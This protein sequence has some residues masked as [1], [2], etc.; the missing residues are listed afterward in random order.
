[1]G[2][3]GRDAEL[4]V[5]A[6][7]LDDVR[8]GRGRA[9]VVVGEPGIGKTAL[10]AAIAGLAAE[11]QLLVLS[12]SGADHP[13]H[14]PFG[15]LEALDARI[16]TLDPRAVAALGPA[17]ADA[18]PAAA[19]LAGEAPVPGG[20]PAARDRRCP[21]RAIRGLLE[22]LGRERPP[23]LLLDDVQDADDASLELVRHL[24]RRPLAGPH[25]LVVAM[26]PAGGAAARLLHAA[27]GAP[28]FAELAL[29]PLGPEASL[30]LLAGVRDPAARRRVARE[31]AGN[32]LFLR[33][34]ASAA[35]RPAPALPATLLAAVGVETARLPLHE[36]RLL[37]GAAAAGDPFDL[38]L[39]AAAAAVPAG[40]EALDR[41]VAAGV[42]RATGEGREFA[43]RHPL[44]RRAVYEAA[45][46]A[47]RLEAH[48]RAAAVLERRGASVVAR[49]PHL[50]RCARPGDAA[51]VA[52]LARAAAAVARS[53]PDTAAGWYA[54]ALRLMPH[55]ARERRAELTAPMGL[56]LAAAGRL[57]AGR[58]AL[59]EALALAEPGPERLVLVRACAEIEAQLGG[60]A[61]ARG[62]LR[63]ALG[64]APGAGQAR[65]AFELAADAMTHGRFADLGELAARTAG[66]AGEDRLLGAGADALRALA[67][68]MTAG[69]DTAAA[70]AVLDGAVARL[71]EL[72]DAALAAHLGVL[73]QIGRVQLRLHRFADASAT[74]AR[75]LAVARHAN[76]RHLTVHLHA[77]RALALC[78]LLDL[79]G[80]LAEVEAAEEAARPHGGPHQELFVLC[81][82]AMAHHHRGEAPEAERAVDAFAALAP[83]RARSALMRAAGANMAAIR[84][85]RDPERALREALDAVGPRLEHTDHLGVSTPLV[86]LTRAAV[87][88]GRLED[89]ERWVADAAARIGDLPLPAARAR[90]DCARAE[91]LLARGAAGAA[92]AL[93]DGAAAAAG[94][95]P[96]PLPA[97][98][99]RLLAG[100]AHAAAGAGSEARLALQRV[101]ADAGRGGAL[102]LRD[103]AR[104]ELRRLGTRVPGDGRTATRGGLTERERGIAELVAL[105][106]A[107][108]QIAAALFLS[109]KTVQNTLTRVYAKLGVRSRTQLVRVLAPPASAWA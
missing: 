87:A 40:A 45:P 102:R 64:D 44:V 12:G 81:L 52:L 101:M 57:D 59:V 19:A 30:R 8:K 89:A 91:L 88:T 74:A 54:A 94:G 86:A 35:E 65:V 53:A 41:L 68:L 103:A 67:A 9:L 33:E 2:M 80:S 83:T 47:W 13:R 58:D 7:A 60:H 11:R 78:Q 71:D 97:A 73:L 15:L 6:E 48:E 1:M 70:T 43:F 42:V 90:V 63:A 34:L 3:L 82:R 92:A 39:A 75:A 17:L 37:E 105:G 106:H 56:A 18:L 72:D 93:A 98:E 84:A 29:E 5:A 50:A 28:G 79:D 55:D 76:R 62:S 31:A 85:E 100:R 38:E 16:A 49:A 107:N 4:A 51:A 66:A 24:L 32:P 69:A 23:A 61:A 109:E 46:P 14:V 25:L 10:L 104:R 96:A 21:R 99:A 36:R 95:V 27:R 108:K 26:R 20:H 22:L 77:V